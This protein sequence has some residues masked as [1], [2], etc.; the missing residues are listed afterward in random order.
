MLVAKELKKT[1]IS[2][3]LIYMFQIE[4]LIRSSSCDYEKLNKV[5]ISK[6]KQPETELVE[7]R[8][9]Y[10]AICRMMNEEKLQQAGH[11]QFVINQMKELTDFHFRLI[12]LSEDEN[13]VKLFKIAASDIEQ[14]RNKIPSKP[15][16]DIEVCL[17]ALYSLLIMRLKQISITAETLEAMTTFSNLLAY[18]SKKHR[19]FEAGEIEI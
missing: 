5:L 10:N 11:L 8:K 19:S 13:Y 6:F 18:L 2:E 3:Y 7:I 14:F 17:Y 1:N 4:D 16:S 9:W 15:S 12:E